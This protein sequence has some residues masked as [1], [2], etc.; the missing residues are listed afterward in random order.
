MLPQLNSY[1]LDKHGKDKREMC[2]QIHVMSVCH[3]VAA[4]KEW[5][6]FGIW[7]R[8][9]VFRDVHSPFMFGAFT[10]ASTRVTAANTI[11]S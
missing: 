11:S 8:S 7:L 10:E 9:Q 2:L 5:K 1:L 4:H 3:S 6:L